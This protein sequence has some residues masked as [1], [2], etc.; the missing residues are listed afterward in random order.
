MRDEVRRQ[1]AWYGG[2][3]HR[4]WWCEDV[5]LLRKGVT[6]GSDRQGSGPA[7]RTKAEALFM[8][9]ERRLRTGQGYLQVARPLRVSRS[10]HV[11][12]T[13]SDA[14]LAMGEK[15]FSEVGSVVS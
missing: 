5:E 14:L 15:A 8:I 2:E 12:P 11:Q 3:I 9:P 4:G 10:G 6:D 1:D 13:E 7:S